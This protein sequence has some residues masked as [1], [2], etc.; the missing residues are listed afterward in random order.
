MTDL[1][2]YEIRYSGT[3]ASAVRGFRAVYL[4]LFFNCLIMATVNLAACKI[5]AIMFGLPRW[6]TLLAVGLLGAGAVNALGAAGTREGF[7]RWGYPRWWGPLTGGL[8]VAGAA[9][10][11][12]PG[13]R[14]LGLALAAAIVAAAV[15]TVLRHREWSHLAPLGV[16]VALIALAAASP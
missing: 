2:F 3:A 9:L 6:Q 1:E 13:T 11:A 8:E 12:L 14:P 15:L 4:G 7:A 10:V 16:F 5:A